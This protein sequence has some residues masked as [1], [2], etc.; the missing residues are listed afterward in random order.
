MWSFL[1]PLRNKEWIE[2]QT[3]NQTAPK[4]AGSLVCSLWPKQMFYPATEKFWSFWQ[5][6]YEAAC[7]PPYWQV[8]LMLSEY[9][10]HFFHLSLIMESSW[11][12]LAIAQP[13]SKAS[14]H[15]WVSIMHHISA[16]L[17]KQVERTGSSWLSPAVSYPAKLISG[18]PVKTAPFPLAGLYPLWK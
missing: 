14:R 6:H 3:S 17:C 18:Q 10:L 2:K 4:K 13:G 7:W 15:S 12:H 8:E 5:Q 11:R 16:L 1:L 9:Q